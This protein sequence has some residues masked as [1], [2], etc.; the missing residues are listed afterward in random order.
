MDRIELTVTTSTKFIKSAQKEEGKFDAIVI[1]E[2]HRLFRDYRKGIAASWVGIYEGKF[3]DCKSHLE[4]IQKAVGTTGQIIL[5]YDVLQSVRPSSITREMFADLTKDYKKEFLKT[6]FRIKAPAGKSYTADD[7]VNGIKYLLF[8]DTGLLESGYTQFNLE[9]NRD[10]FRDTSPDAYFGFFEDH[11]LANAHQWIITKGIYNSSDSNRVLAGYVEP[12]KMSDGQDKSI[13][14]WNEGDVHLRW[15]SSQ[16]G[17]IN[18]ND[19]DARDQV[20]S[21]YAV[22]GIDLNRAAVLI[23]PDLVVGTD[24]ALKGS[25]EGCCDVNTKFKKE[26]YDNDQVWCDREFTLFILNCYY[27]LL[28]RGIDAIRVGFWKDNGSPTL[29]EYM[30]NTLGIEP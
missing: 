1:D 17:W 14:H 21:V 6:Q 18:S 10:V 30:K 2:A 26:D 15:N 27:I 28:T 25:M 19:D 5:M 8:K 29:L 7:Y 4:I 24:G 9:F 3:K 22:Q 20:G 11:P 23:G 12:W 16:E 13:K